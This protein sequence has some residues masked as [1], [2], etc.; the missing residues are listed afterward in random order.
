MIIFFF[1]SKDYE[2]LQVSTHFFNKHALDYSYFKMENV[3]NIIEHM[4]D[5][6]SQVFFIGF[7]IK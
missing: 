2:H 1:L 4:N 7:D 6:T 5:T 3:L